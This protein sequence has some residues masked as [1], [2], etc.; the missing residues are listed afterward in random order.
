[1]LHSY[2][3]R[4][5]LGRQKELRT[6]PAMPHYGT[7]TPRASLS[8]VCAWSL[9]NMTQFTSYYTSVS[10]F[11]VR[12]TLLTGSL[13]LT[14]LLTSLVCECKT[15]CGATS[16]PLFSSLQLCLRMRTWRSSVRSVLLGML[17]SVDVLALM[18]AHASAVGPVVK[19]LQQTGRHLALHT[20]ARA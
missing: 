12:W 16:G 2:I 8:F 20:M 18:T 13:L 9:T 17:K 15:S 7:P 14:S 5:L 10:T 3:T 19:K 11:T 4:V 6:G 1:M